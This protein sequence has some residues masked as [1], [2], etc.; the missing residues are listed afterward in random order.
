MHDDDGASRH[1]QSRRLRER[2]SACRPALPAP[3]RL[4]PSP[5]AS[6]T[7]TRTRGDSP[8]APRGARRE[9]RHRVG[10]TP[11]RSANTG[12]HG[13][14][15]R[16]HRTDSSRARL[17]ARRSTERARRVPDL[18]RAAASTVLGRHPRSTSASLGLRGRRTLLPSSTVRPGSIALTTAPGT[19]LVAAEHALGLLDWTTGDIV[20]KLELNIAEPTV[21]LNDGRV[22]RSGN[23]W[24]GTMHV[25]QL[26]S[27][28]SDRCSACD[29]IGR[30][31]RCSPTSESPTGWPSAMTEPR[32]TSLTRSAL[33]VWRFDIDSTGA[34][35]RRV[36]FVDFGVAR[37][38]RQ[39]G[40]SM[41]R[42]GR[43]LLDRVRPRLRYRQ[44]HPA[45]G[46]R[47]AD[48]A[49]DPATHCVAFGGPTLATL[50]VTS[51]G[52]GPSTTPCSTTNR[53]A[54]ALRS[55]R[56]CDGRRGGGVR[57]F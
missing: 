21:R 43:V 18:G 33:T 8:T 19:L 3:R 23:F 29:R 50:F 44:D 40:W 26:M 36:P 12:P 1:L 6:P 54:D 56:R 22:D 11:P 20:W 31:T 5:P 9:H 27:D 32:C 47:P 48:P 39:A 37:T 46:R 42:R 51:I 35:G 38:A 25:P 34:L 52:G 15:A 45:R 17:C 57:F 2:S 53:T 13:R 7:A 28:T 30:P 24:V 4:G 41:P 16:E 49:A 10:S 55:R 14:A